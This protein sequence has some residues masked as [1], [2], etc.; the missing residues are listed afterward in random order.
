MYI[1]NHVEVRLNNQQQ[2]ILV[3]VCSVATKHIHKR[4]HTTD[5][6]S[7]QDVEVGL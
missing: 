1:S 6:A 2:E 5:D 3:A 4:D 7:M